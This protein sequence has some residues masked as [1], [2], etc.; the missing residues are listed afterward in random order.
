MA[1]LILQGFDVVNVTVFIAQYLFQDFPGREI[2]N[3]A[4]QF[5]SVIIR[6]DRVLFGRVVIGK[7]RRD[8]GTDLYFLEPADYRDALQ[9]KDAA[10]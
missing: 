4:S 9:K 10:D 1:D 6:L 8:L 7:L 3:V 5:D 2:G